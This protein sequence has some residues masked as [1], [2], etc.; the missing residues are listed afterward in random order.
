[1]EF[2]KYDIGS[3][4]IEEVAVDEYV[5]VMLKYILMYLIKYVRIYLRLELHSFFFI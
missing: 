1:M 3:Q 2:I 5:N 4:V